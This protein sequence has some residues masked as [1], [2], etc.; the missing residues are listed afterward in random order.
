MVDC[1]LKSDVYKLSIFEIVRLQLKLLKFNKYFI[2]D[3]VSFLLF[4]YKKTHFNSIIYQIIDFLNKFE[5]CFP[6]YIEF[7]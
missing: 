5:V 2:V 7:I 6:V 1:I 4:K 3:R